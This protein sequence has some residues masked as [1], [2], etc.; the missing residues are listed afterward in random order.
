[1]R[2]LFF[3]VASCFV[4][5][6]GF[7]PAAIAQQQLTAED[8]RE[9]GTGGYGCEAD[10]YVASA[11]GDPGEASLGCF[12]TAEAAAAYSNTGE[13][14]QP[15]S[16]PAPTPVNCQDSFISVAGNPSQFSAQQFYDFNATPEEQA[17]LD[18]DGDGIACEGLLNGEQE[19]TPAAV[20]TQ[21]APA[22]NTGVT[23]LPDTGGP[24]L[25][26]LA[27]GLALILGGLLLYKRLN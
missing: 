19:G 15:T 22:S 11:P 18:P 13:V 26:L 17:I 23:E 21:Q 24:A 25:P 3:L 1:M 6:V 8:F 2:R 20:P 5:S 9:F 14:P 27:G 10:Q 7:A 12:D 4:M 16:Q